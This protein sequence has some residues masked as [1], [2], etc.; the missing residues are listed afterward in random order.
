MGLKVHWTDEEINKL[1]ILN[2]QNLP[3]EEMAKALNRSYWGTLKK[4]GELKL[5]LPTA[6]DRKDWTK[7]ELDSLKEFYLE[8]PPKIFAQKYQ[9]WAAA[10]GYSYRTQNNLKSKVCRLEI[11]RA[12]YNPKVLTDFQISTGLGCSLGSVRFWLEHH[13]E[14]LN[15]I[16]IALGRYQVIDKN[17][18]RFL[19]RHPEV[20][21]RYRSSVDFV[22]LLDLIGGKK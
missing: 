22:W 5:R 16:Q 1:R 21:E 11:K 8:F 9:E 15:P 12:D 3:V 2:S 7:E 6:S 4:A 18:R 17:F 20:V 10:N 14:I 13:K 19:L